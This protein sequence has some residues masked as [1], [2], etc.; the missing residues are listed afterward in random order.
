MIQKT[1]K[2]QNLIVNVDND[3][4]TLG[5]SATDLVSQRLKE[6][7]KEKGKAAIILATG[8]SQFEFLGTLKAR[9]DI[10]WKKII[11][12][13]LDE[14]K[15]ISESHPAS[16]RK[17]LKERILNLVKPGQIYFINGN[18]ED[19]QKECERYEVLLRHNKIDIACIGIGEN[20]HLAFNDPHVADFNDNRL[21][22]VVTLDE[23]CRRQQLGEGWFKSLEDVPCEAVTLTI[24]AIMSA[25]MI[26][27]VVPDK[28]KAC[29]VR[30]ALKGDI[31]TK[32]PA[33]IL[34]RHS[35]V[36]L[37]LDAA[38]AELLRKRTDL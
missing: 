8:A 32:C 31:S 12:F 20:G 24:P 6:V 5:K 2:V 11:V 13:H 3:K 22:K 18:A 30:D 23:A 35:N 25:E 38:S 19:T 15:G 34:R 4:I 14:Y 10:D 27:C 33:S 17:Y 37:F 16:F 26:S 36:H 21:V 29:A 1:F 9:N 28:R 7:I